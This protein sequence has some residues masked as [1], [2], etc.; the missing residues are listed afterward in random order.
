MTYTAII[1]HIR[2]RHFQKELAQ[3][4]RES[5]ITGTP[6]VFIKKVWPLKLSKILF[7]SLATKAMR[8]IDYPDVI[9]FKLAASRILLQSF[10]AYLSSVSYD[11]KL[12]LDDGQQKLL[13]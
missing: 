2:G 7:I 10:K 13:R 5:W 11:F 1:R 8:Y 12:T 4:P 3:G 9:N 6:R